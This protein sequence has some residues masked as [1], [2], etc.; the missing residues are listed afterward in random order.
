MALEHIAGVVAIGFVNERYLKPRF[1]NEVSKVI[2]D[3]MSF[4]IVL[5][6]VLLDFIGT[7]ETTEF[8]FVTIIIFLE[9][10]GIVLAIFKQGW[11][12]SMDA[13][14]KGIN[15]KPLDL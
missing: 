12:T 11:K 10:L 15:A 13:L 6:G 9:V 2:I 3:I 5:F 7:F 14:S 8:W 1:D 4:A